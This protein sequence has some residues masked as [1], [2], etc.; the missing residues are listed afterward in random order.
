MKNKIIVSSIL[1]IALCL[2]MIAGST[3]A[4]FTSQS[5]VNVAVTSGTVKIVATPS[6]PEMGSTLGSYLGSATQGTGDKVNELTLDKFVPGDYAT[7]TIS[8]DNQSDVSVKF[9]TVISVSND[10]GLASGL[11]FTIGGVEYKNSQSGELAASD[12]V[13]LAA[14]EGDTTVDV[15]VALPEDAGN[16]YQNKTCTLTYKVEAIQGNVV[17]PTKVESAEE[18]KTTLANAQPGDVIDATG[19]IADLRYLGVATGNRSIMDVAS[20]VTIKGLTLSFASQEDFI[21]PAAGT[22]G[23]I[24]FENCTFQANNDFSHSFNVKSA[25]DTKIVFNNCTFEGSVRSGST[26]GG[27]VEY[28]N[29]S[30]NLNKDGYAYVQC[31]VGNHTFNSCTFNI[32]SSY[33]FFDTP[34]TKYGKINLYAD[35]AG[36]TVTVTLNQCVGVP[37]IHK[38]AVNGGSCVVK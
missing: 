19:V 12:W 27:E 26:T 21:Q 7:F 9:R 36:T 28:N 32:S 34:M 22:V 18:L 23:E 10:T 35:T 29:C 8:I 25:K 3:F 30:F 24:V 37:S 20:G 16:T 6:A 33:V 5:Q 38:Y 14:G 11:V 17:F 15:K 4:L 1:T 31:F 13:T 2:S